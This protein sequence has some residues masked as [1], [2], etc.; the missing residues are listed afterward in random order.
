MIVEKV[1]EIKNAQ[2]Y[3]NDA[4]VL[5][6]VNFE[7]SGSDFVFMIGKTGTGKSSFLKL[8]YGELALNE[9]EGTVAGFDL[10]TLKRKHIPML[11]RKIGIVFQDFQLLTDR[12]VIMNLFF[13]M[14]ATGWKDKKEM[15]KRAIELLQ[16]VGLETKVN[17]MAYALSGGEQQRLA[18]ARALINK[19][20]II[21]ADEP[22]GN[23][24]PETSLEIMSLLIAVAKE[25]KSAIFMAT[26]DL[27]MIEKF[28]GRV[29][30]L[31]NQTLREINTINRFNPFEPFNP[32][33][34]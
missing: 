6:D 16:L 2:L 10:K 31:E 12:T 9:G 27:N 20:E 29:I 22:T 24:D 7:M 32:S 23:L 5:K 14:G 15:E 8:L 13:V 3:Q 26:H 1:I 11:R 33:M 30:R 25:E 21:L 28:P 18:I 34:G 19:P 4:L 17:A